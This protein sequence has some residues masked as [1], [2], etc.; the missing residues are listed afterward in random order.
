MTQNNFGRMRKFN[1]IKPWFSNVLKLRRHILRLAQFNQLGDKNFDEIIANSMCDSKLSP[2]Q[3]VSEIKFLMELIRDKNIR[4]VCEIGSYKGGSMYLF[5]QAL[6]AGAKLISVDINYPI[7]R[8]W[9][10]KNF[11]RDNQKIICIKANSQD[12]HTVNRVRKALAGKEID[13]LFIDGDHSFFGVTNDFILY[14]PLVRSGGF[15][16]FH[17]IHPVSNTKSGV[18]STAYVGEVPIFW[19]AL[20]SAGFSFT[21]IIEDANQDGKGI[22][23][24][25]KE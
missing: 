11:A 4:T 7:E 25:V 19:S 16:A 24:I 6:R 5:S 22:G 23:V 2:S 18:K 3:K 10:N 8:R 14:S 17:D 9:L 1:Q 12:I 15:I 20:K 13:L 21:E